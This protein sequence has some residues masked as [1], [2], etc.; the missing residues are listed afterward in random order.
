MG[1]TPPIATTIPSPIQMM[2][3]LRTVGPRVPTISRMLTPSACEDNL[4]AGMRLIYC[5]VTQTP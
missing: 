3:K 4:Q 5:R 1:T 2:P